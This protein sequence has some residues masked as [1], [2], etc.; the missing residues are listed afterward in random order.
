MFA[1]VAVSAI[2]ALSDS[3]GATSVTVDKPAGTVDGDV[4]FALVKQGVDEALTATGWT[5]LLSDV[6]GSSSVKHSLLRKVASSEGA[7]YPFSWATSTRGGASI[8]TY[9]DG[10]D[11]G[12]PV[13]VSS[14]TSYETND[15]IVQAASMT[16]T[17]VNSPLLFFQ[18]QHASS[19]QSFTPP[20]SPTG[21]VEDGGDQ[22]DTSSRFMRTCSSLLWS[23]SGATGVVEGATATTQAKHAFMVAFTPGAGGVQHD[24]FVTVLFRAA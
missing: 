7:S 13:D 23:S 15:T 21:W 3:S 10:F 16:V 14:N 5:L 12:A 24:P 18:M 9:R 1:F 4:M 8:W 20:T 22:Q 19:N 6:N 17:A 2:D 11:S